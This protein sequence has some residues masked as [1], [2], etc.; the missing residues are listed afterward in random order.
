MDYAKEIGR[1][2]RAARDELGLTL[3]ELSEETGFLLS[4]SRINNYEKGIRTP[5]PGE[6]VL[7][8]RA[9]AVSSP[10]YLMCLERGK[11]VFP[12][13]EELIHNWRKLPEI[14]RNKY[15]RSISAMALAYQ[16]NVLETKLQTKPAQ[17]IRK[18]RNKA[19]RIKT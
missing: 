3:D 14:E 11:D 10:A 9:L 19:A 2:V 16:D 13:E 18:K 1:R 5:G 8:A 15:V 12:K 7:L 4:P 17:Q 6:I